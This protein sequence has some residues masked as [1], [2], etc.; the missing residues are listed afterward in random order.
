[1]MPLN[2]TTFD[3]ANDIFNYLGIHDT[4][5]KGIQHINTQ[6]NDAQQNDAQHNDA[7]HNDT[8]HNDTQHNYTQPSG[9][10]CDTL[11][12]DTQRSTLVLIGIKLC[13]IILEVALFK[14]YAE[15][16]YA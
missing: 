5:H 1:M 8:Q 14:C 11:H 10:N 12:N 3:N 9:L 16:H 13:I 6:H 7:Q 15:Y 4:Q 2:I